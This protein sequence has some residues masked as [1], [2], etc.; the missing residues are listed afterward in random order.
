MS[1]TPA[2]EPAI[3]TGTVEIKTLKVDGK[4]MTQ[5]FFRQLIEQPVISTV[6]RINGTPW[7]VVNYHPDSCE[8]SGEH[9]HV[10]WQC[11]GQLRRAFTP[12]PERALVRHS[13]IG[14]F[15]TARVVEGERRPVPWTPGG[16]LSISRMASVGEVAAIVNVRGVQFYSP[17]S[18]ALLNAW[19]RQS[20]SPAQAD[21]LRAEFARA[22][23]RELRP[24]A[25]VAE[26]IPAEAHKAAWRQ[27][28]DL[29]QLFIG[30]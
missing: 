18:V 9:L 1:T 13:L 25:E 29:P 23:D 5:A 6:G 27:L 11:N 2:H 22:Y 12:A 4:Q 19:E 30:R 21:H 28:S 24:A 16:P 7:G 20:D 15:V 26:L 14:E 17:V 10:I 8:N 3:E